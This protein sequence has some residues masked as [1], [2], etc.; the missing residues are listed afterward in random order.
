MRLRG[1]M[2]MQA[3]AAI[4][5]AFLPGHAGVS[6]PWIYGCLS[7]AAC[8]RVGRERISIPAT[9]PQWT[10]LSEPGIAIGA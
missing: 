3:A 4:G 8:Q 1:R 5:I 2:V 7:A 9:A 10:R 6:C